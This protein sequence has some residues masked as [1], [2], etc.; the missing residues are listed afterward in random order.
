VKSDTLTSYEVG[1]KS[2]FWDHR[3]ILNLAAFDLEWNNI[4]VVGSLPGG[5]TYTTNG[6][7]ARSRG[8]QADASIRPIDRLILQGT[9][10]YTDAKLTE[11]VPSV[12]GFNGDRLPYVPRWSGSLRADY[13]WPLTG[14]WDLHAGGGLRLVGD[15]YSTGPAS[16]IQYKTPGYNALDLNL[17]VANARWTIGLFAKNVTD[18]RAYLTDVAI[19]NGVTG[20][21]PLVEGDILQPR[22]V[23]IS[24]DVKM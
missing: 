24:L 15:R 11:D 20:A 2:T 23:G 5:Y 10:A 22:T 6:G 12:G 19:Q 18:T 4:Q 8:F 7:T 16:I 3:V 21:V 13:S 14:A 17:S 1:L 9:L